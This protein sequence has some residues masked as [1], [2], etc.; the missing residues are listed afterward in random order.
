MLSKAIE[1]LEVKSRNYADINVFDLYNLKINS[2]ITDPHHYS[3]GMDYVKD[4]FDSFYAARELNRNFE[5]LNKLPF[6]STF[7]VLFRVIVELTRNASYILMFDAF[8]LII[9][10]TFDGMF[11]SSE[12]IL[13]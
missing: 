11:L 4:Y 13:T 7:E 8:S 6:M 1:V 3:E 12:E 9:N 5:E 2:T 10:E